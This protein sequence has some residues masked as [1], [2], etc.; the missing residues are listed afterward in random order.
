MEFSGWNRIFSLPKNLPFLR[1]SLASV[2]LRALASLAM[3]KWIAVAF[4]PA[5]TAIFGQFI[6]LFGSFSSV[7]NDGLARAMVREGAFFS[8]S[9]EEKKVG[10]IIGSSLI[11][12]VILLVIQWIAL[13]A[14]GHFTHWFEP[15]QSS[16]IWYW[17]FPALSALTF[18]FLSSNFF[19]VRAQTQHQTTLVTLISFGALSG[20]AISRWLGLELM[21]MLLLLTFGQIVF[22]LMFLGLRFHK[23][24]I[25]WKAFQWNGEMAKK[26]LSFA[27]VVSFTALLSKVADFSLVTWAMSFH[28]KPTVGIW[29]AMN[30]LAD[31]ANIPIL[32]VVNGILI[33]MLSGKTANPSEIKAIIRP[34]FKQLVFW[35]A[36]GFSV[37][38]FFYPII[39]SLLFS[40]EFHAQTDW[41]SFQILGD[42]FK[43][44]AYLISGLCLALGATR[45]YFWIETISIVIVVILTVFFSHYL[46]E[47]GLFVAHCFRY[48]LF[49]LAL[50]FRFRQFL[51]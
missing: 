24:N 33:P 9:G 46:G 18:T 34:L 42:F 23:L 4:G 11:L 2:G 45:F 38:Y 32:A 14:L 21:P 43:S 10:Q 40:S 17:L 47:T 15:F 48:G 41:V 44:N 50:V 20:L 12:F 31:S 13:F 30:R 5:G 3:N 7:A 19:L 35:T 6:N 25:H 28:G 51:L 16:P 29:L 37:V 1:F 22:G 8:A 26:T 36:V 39:L 49:L 27:L